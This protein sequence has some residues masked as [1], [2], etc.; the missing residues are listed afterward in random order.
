MACIQLL[1]FCS[2]IWHLVFV[3]LSEI[4][5][6]SPQ[7]RCYVKTKICRQQ[8]EQKHKIAAPTGSRTQADIKYQCR[9]TNALNHCTNGSFQTYLC[10]ASYRECTRGHVL[11]TWQIYCNVAWQIRTVQSLGEGGR[12]MLFYKFRLNIIYIFQYLWIIS[13]FCI[14][15]CIAMTVKCH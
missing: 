5:P 3:I 15:H 6:C 13:L 14:T 4:E 7:N 1:S 12:K 9:E 11:Y 10:L 2:L 8:T